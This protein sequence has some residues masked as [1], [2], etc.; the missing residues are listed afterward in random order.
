MQCLPAVCA[1]PACLQ[2]RLVSCS[3]SIGL[4]PA[5]VCAPSRAIARRYAVLQVG[6]HC[7]EC[8]EDGY[9]YDCEDC[10]DQT[11]EIGSNV[12]INDPDNDPYTVMWELTSGSGIISNPSAVT[13]S[14]KLE[15]IEATEPNVCDSNEWVLELTVTDCTTAS[16]SESTTVTVDCCGIEAS[17]S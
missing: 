5:I 17:G 9:V 4:R 1:Y 13:T 7:V 3:V 8:E 12:T 11:I 10:E 14:V 6:Q 16:T 15:N 2:E